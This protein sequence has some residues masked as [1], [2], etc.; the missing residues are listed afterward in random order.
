VVP[1][2]TT[3]PGSLCLSEVTRSSWEGTPNALAA[4]GSNRAGTQG[5]LQMVIG[6][7]GDEEG[8]PVSSA[9]FPGHRHAPQ[10]WAAQVAKRKGRVGVHAM[11]FVGDRGLSKSQQSADLA[12]QGFHAMTAM[13]KPQLDKLLRPGTCPMELCE[14]EVA[15]G[16]ADEGVR[17]GRRRRPVRAQAVREKRQATLATLQALVAQHNHDLKEQPR[18]AAPGAWQKL[19]A[20]ATTFRLADGVELP[21]EARAI[22]LTVHASGQQEAAQLDGGSGL[23]TDL[24]PAQA[25]KE[26]VHERD[27][28]LAAVARAWRSCKTVH[29]AMRPIFLRLEERTRA[30][31]FVVMLASQIIRYL[32]SCWSACD[33]TVAA[34]LQ[35]LTTLCLVEVAPPNAP[36]YHCIPTPRAA[37]AP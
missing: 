31:A 5:Q 22:T 35:A 30:H 26:M 16:L 33:V 34:G 20:R 27:K 4:F 29:L 15:E 14:P 19:V 13:T 21:L 12:Q 36:S 3:T 25:P 6:L 8:H 2:T 18:A 17:D 37:V 10:T 1:R 28:A 9:G 7:L 11:P 24:T 32:A 23:K